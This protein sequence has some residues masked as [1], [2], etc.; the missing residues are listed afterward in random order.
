MKTKRDAMNIFI[1]VLFLLNILFL[2]LAS[3]KTI[4]IAFANDLSPY[5]FIDEKDKEKGFLIDYWKLW[6]KKVKVELEFLPNS[7]PNA[8]RSI[9]KG[10]ADIHAG[11]LYVKKR[12]KYLEYLGPIYEASLSIYINRKNINTIKNIKDLEGKRVAVVKGSHSANYLKKHHPLIKLKVYLS[13]VK[14]ANSIYT[15]EIDAVF[16][17]SLT[18]WHELIK[19]SKFSE[20]LRLTNFNAKAMVY[21]GLSKKNLA[22]K[23]LIL[24][25]IKKISKKELAA[26]EKKW[27]LDKDLGKYNKEKS[28]D[29]L[30]LEERQYLSKN[31]KINLAFIK[32]WK[33]M[34]FYNKNN[35]MS[36]YHVDLLEEINKN[37]ST[38]ITYTV[39]PNWSSAYAAS[40]SGETKGIIGLSWTKEREKYFLYSPSYF[41][42]PFY[43]Y[44]NA[45]II[46]TAIVT[47][48]N[49]LSLA[50]QSVAS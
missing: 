40:I 2:S 47:T 48:S 44:C 32:G 11:L 16:S 50:E 22:L 38:K 8:L 15:N 12:E 17:E 26:L 10:E 9:K 13:Y 7:W 4:K 27:V 24:E 3:S 1:K 5:Y 19:S 39:F 31:K 43:L 41:F 6:A 49:T 30:S 42:T 28:S 37:L 29:I 23:E 14:M 33:L 35:K 46:A 25:G 18:M 20:I 21:T 34:S 36:G 45:T